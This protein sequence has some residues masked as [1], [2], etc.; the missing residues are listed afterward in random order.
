MVAK[1]IVSRSL[2]AVVHVATAVVVL[3]NVAV[4]VVD[5]AAC[6]KVVAAFC[7]IC[8]LT[9]AKPREPRSLC[10]EESVAFAK[11]SSTGFADPPN[12][13]CSSVGGAVSEIQSCSKKQ[14]GISKNSKAVGPVWQPL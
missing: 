8:W 4:L 14:Q 2:F 3:L 1:A 6:C 10:S 11:H 7:L 12:S 5:T 13:S 9:A